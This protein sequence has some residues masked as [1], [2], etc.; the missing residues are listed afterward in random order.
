MTDAIPP[1][2]RASPP[3]DVTEF[4]IELSV[5]LHKHAMY[6]EGHPS[7]GPA[8]E[9]V[10][11]H[12]ERLLGDRELLAFGVARHQLIIDGV[13][14]DAQQPVLRRLA[15][16]LHRHHLG[17]VSLL[18][19]LQPAEVA[20]ALR[21]LSS[22]PDRDGPLP[23]SGGQLPGCDHVRLHLLTFDGLTIVG[24]DSPDGD[25]GATSHASDLWI[26]LARAALAGEPDDHEGTDGPG[27]GPDGR[28]KTAEPGRVADAIDRHHGAEAYDQVVVGYLL[29]IASEL[30]TATGA[31]AQAL[32]SRSARLISA[33]KPDTLRRLVQMGGDATRR[34][35]FIQDASEGMAVEAVVDL[36]KA[37]ADASGQT[38]SHGLV[39][40]LTKLSAH[41][42]AGHDTA[43]PA[44]DRALREQVQSLLSEWELADPNPADYRRMLEYLA[45]APA[46]PDGRSTA[47]DDLRALRL[48][49]MSLEVGTSGPLV[50]RAISTCLNDGGAQPLVA[51]LEQAP[52][53]HGV[54]AD[55]LRARL[56]QPMAI[57]AIA[58]REPLDEAS[59][60]YLMPALSMEGYATLLD[61]LA[62]SR[63]R[64]TRRK[65]LERLATT[66][67][68]VVAL[69]ASRLDDDRWYVQRNMLLLLARMGRVPDRF[70]L[71]RWTT[72]TDER[73]RSEALRLQMALPGQREVALRAAFSDA[74]PRVVRVGVGAVQQGCPPRVLPFLAGLAAGERVPEDL[75]LLAVQALGNTRDEAALDA[76]FAVASG[77]KTLLGRQKLAP[78]STVVLAALRALAASWRKH[79]KVEPLLG[80]AATSTDDDFRA[81]V[82]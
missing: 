23:L 11:R 77:G 4:L 51:V 16:G 33:L 28:R 62:S 7:L 57:G 74:D 29:Q 71:A 81:A 82:R 60:D 12:A 25:E 3:R 27:A 66:P 13:A 32:R 8:A 80:L 38:I 9:G 55:R 56:T 36:V 63:S 2:S 39:R 22:E 68:D 30:K 35:A 79:P 44:A 64:V 45:T 21:A 70:P 42:E 49:Q 20:I 46:N 19:G 24:G 48:V 65:L 54:A 37:A 58:S 73:L 61:V 78:K 15:E 52:E 31:E 18:R 14:T 43:K 26:G 47:A 6:P 40:M 1:G 17:A 41:A 59:L 67:L 72:H 10:T 53:Q 76:I 75:R 5:A 34:N 69:V 50:D